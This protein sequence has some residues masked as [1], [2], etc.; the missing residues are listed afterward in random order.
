MKSNQVAE[1]VWLGAVN[2]SQSPGHPAAFP[3]LQQG[4]PWRTV[5]C[6]LVPCSV[7]SRVSLPDS[8]QTKPR[9]PRPLCWESAQLAS[10]KNLI[11]FKKMRL[12]NHG[13]LL[14]FEVAFSYHVNVLHKC[15]RGHAGFMNS[16]VVF[17]LF[18]ESIATVVLGSTQ[19][20][21]P[22]CSTSYAT[23]VQCFSPAGRR[24]K[25]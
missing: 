16:Q 10:L 15:L 23:L 12:L 14:K 6:H 25:G 19:S 8:N 7:V 4:V 1:R 9:Y 17:C 11:Q 18:H 21:I 3:S 2:L 13:G 22:F 20:F 5:R 24:E